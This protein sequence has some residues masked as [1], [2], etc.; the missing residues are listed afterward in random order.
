MV[1]DAEETVEAI[2][3]RVR[4]TR[5]YGRVAEE[6]V[7]RVAR[8]EVGSHPR[9][10]D[11]LQATQRRLHQ[12]CGAYLPGRVRYDQWLARLRAARETSDDAYRE[13]ARA[14]MALHA[15]TRERLPILH[16]FYREALEGL[17]PPRSV[18]DVA[19]GLGPL[20][21]P[22]MPL[23]PG[24]TYHAYDAYEDLAEFM[25]GCLALM[26]LQGHAEARDVLARPPDEPADLALVLKFLP[27][28]EQLETGAGLRL[29]ERLRAQHL[30]VSFPARTLGGRDVG[31][32]ETYT[33]QLEEELVARQWSWHKVAFEEEPA[34]LI[35]R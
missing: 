9:E 3:R 31:M 35:S 6:L 14:M 21:A 7:R 5:K 15:S 8:A 27:N 10:R 22:W 18:V 33:A 30:L 2:V 11:A 17:S 32:V 29:L 19:C 28:A 12:V 24:A 20:A 1:G 26:G 23:A 4:A 16:R 13:T 25:A 34:Y